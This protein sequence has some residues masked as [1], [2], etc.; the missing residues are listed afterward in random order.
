MCVSHAFD[1]TKNLLP[2][3]GQKGS[4]IF[5]DG[6]G[7]VFKMTAEMEIHTI[8]PSPPNDPWH[9]CLPDPLPYIVIRMR[10]KQFFLAG[11]TDPGV[12]HCNINTFV[13]S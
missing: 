11:L 5:G 7:Q 6:Q 13:T 9:F 4:S 12:L 3:R 2:S 8:A 1:L 10:E